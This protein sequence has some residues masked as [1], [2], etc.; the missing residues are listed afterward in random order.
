M[1]ALNINGVRREVDVPADMPLLW[2]LRDVL[3]VG[4]IGPRA[5]TTIEVI[6]ATPNAVDPDTIVAQLQGGHIFG[7]TAALY[8]EITLEKGRVQ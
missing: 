2:V 7:L 5:V 8:G 4:N 3:P 1:L 6:S